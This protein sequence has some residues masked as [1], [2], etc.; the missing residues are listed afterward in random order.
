MTAGPDIIKDFSRLQAQVDSLSRANVGLAGRNLELR[1]R[2]ERA[3][4][5]LWQVGLSP[6]HHPELEDCVESVINIIEGLRADLTNPPPD[7]QE[8]V[9]RC[10]EEEHAGR[11]ELAKSHSMLGQIA[12]EVM[13][14]CEHEE[15]TTLQAVQLMKCRMQ[16]LES[17]NR[18][19][20]IEESWK[21]E[22][23]QA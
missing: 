19:R 20:E 12:M 18:R 17:E 14:Y 7:V 23:R 8:R 21:L 3:A 16:E 9:L 11:E 15:C 4:G 2:I 10:F 6:R 13:D 1:E 22:Q 5:R